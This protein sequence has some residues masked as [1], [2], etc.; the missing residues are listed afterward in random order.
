MKMFGILLLFLI[1]E[2]IAGAQETCL[3][4]QGD[5]EAGWVQYKNACYRRFDSRVSW[6]AA[7]AACLASNSHLASIHSNEEN[8]FVYTLMGKPGTLTSEALYWIGAHDTFQEG[9]FIF[10][11]GSK[12]NENI[13]DN[14]QPDNYQNIEH[15]VGTWRFNNGHI[16][17]NDYGLTGNFLRYVCKY[18]LRNRLCGTD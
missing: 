13:F 15:Y 10:T 16:K 11:D 5:C 2:V 4:A 18:C 6:F 8:D 12:I 14:G 17:W 7:E 9:N 3:C 1:I